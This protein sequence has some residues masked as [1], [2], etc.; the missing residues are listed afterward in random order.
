MLHH[1]KCT[2]RQ[3]PTALRP[4]CMANVIISGTVS[5]HTSVSVFN[6]IACSWRRPVLGQVEEKESTDLFVRR[7]LAACIARLCCGIS[8]LGNAKQY[9]LCCNN[10]FK[11]GPIVCVRSS[12]YH[13]VLV[14][15]HCA[16]TA[17]VAQILPAC[18]QLLVQ[19]NV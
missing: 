15:T 9:R 4:S 8:R 18:I 12:K 10:C 5:R 1:H 3:G 17:S 13:S 16:V 19:V 6:H 14:F 2:V 11:W 7:T